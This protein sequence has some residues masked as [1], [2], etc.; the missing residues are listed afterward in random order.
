MKIKI[1][2]FLFTQ[3]AGRGSWQDYFY[4]YAR[5]VRRTHTHDVRRGCSLLCLTGS[6]FKFKQGLRVRC[7]QYSS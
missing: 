7:W 1:P 6:G 5:T 2:F 4:Y 3:D